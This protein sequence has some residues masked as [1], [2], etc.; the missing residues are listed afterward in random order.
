MIQSITA[1]IREKSANWPLYARCTFH[2][3]VSQ[4]HEVSQ[5]SEVFVAMTAFIHIPTLFTST[6]EALLY[7]V[8]VRMSQFHHA[9]HT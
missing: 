2:F 6:N 4:N 5:K 8:F 1:S 3:S 9:L 7:Y